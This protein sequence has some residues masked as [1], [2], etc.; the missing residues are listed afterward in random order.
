MAYDVQHT[1]EYAVNV[2][3]T[4]RPFIPVNAPT[5]DGDGCTTEQTMATQKAQCLKVSPAAVMV[6]GSNV[7]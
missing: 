4:D 3:A 5:S 6:K 1:V 2:P 7:G